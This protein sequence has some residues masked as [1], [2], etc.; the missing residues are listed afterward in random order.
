MIIPADCVASNTTEA[1]AGALAEM[2]KVLK[3]DVGPSEKVH[4]SAP[5]G[6]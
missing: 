5:E 6:A 2:A 4:F 3:A 1:T